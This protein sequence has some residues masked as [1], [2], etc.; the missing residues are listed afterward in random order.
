M[1]T[2]D[3]QDKRTA[4]DRF[5][6]FL[7]GLCLLHCLAIPF[8]ALLGPALGHWLLDTETDVH[9]WLLALAVPISLWALGRGYVNHH[10]RLT[11]GLGIAGLGCMFLGVSHWAGEDFEVVLTAVGVVAVMIAHIRNAFANLAQH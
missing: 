2:V 5:A 4:L 11:L 9:W 8:A 3:Q 1:S 7:S 10:N 6:I